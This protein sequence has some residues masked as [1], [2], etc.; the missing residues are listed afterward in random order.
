V[1]VDG[2]G[3]P[4]AVATTPANRHDG[5]QLLPLLG[6]L[7]P[8]HGPRG[9]PRRWPRALYGDR[10]YGSDANRIACNARG[11]TPFLPRPGDPHGSGLGRVRWVV[12][13][14]LAWFNGFRRLRV[15]YER[16]AAHWQALHELA[17]ALLCWTRLEN[18]T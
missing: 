5:T 1:I 15:C 13:R 11:I 9:R 8:L 12:E 17:A 16:T 18:A 3:T 6:R 10:A 14:T 4:L 7:P 2:A